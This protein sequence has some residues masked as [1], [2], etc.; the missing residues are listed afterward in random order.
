MEE[1]NIPRS[2]D[3]VLFENKRG[4]RFVS[5]S[6]GSAGTN[7]L[8]EP[9]FPKIA[10]PPNYNTNF[11][12]PDVWTAETK[13]KILNPRLSATSIQKQSN[14]IYKTATNNW[15]LV[16]QKNVFLCLKDKEF[17]EEMKQFS[18]KNAENVKS[19]ANL[20]RKPIKA[21]KR[22]LNKVITHI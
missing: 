20:A 17:N 22:G 5:K 11:R 7:F 6:A 4:S 13:L 15:F 1:L 18:T 2:R 19:A 12:R 10:K 16:P 9:E 3:I 14:Q 21:Y 8:K